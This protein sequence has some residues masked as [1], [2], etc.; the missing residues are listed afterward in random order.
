MGLKGS[1]GLADRKPCEVVDFVRGNC[2][3]SKGISRCPA[4]PTEVVFALDMSNDVSQSDFERMRDIL[5]S[6]LMK[7]EV[8]ESNCPTGARVA[9]VSY[10]MKTDYLVRLPDHRGQAGLLQAVRKIP[11]ERSSGSRNLGATMRFVA[12]HV[13]KRVRSGLLVR[14]V[15]VF[16]Q[17]GRNYDTTSVS[18]AMLELHAADI[19][20][21][22]VTFTEEH[23]LPEAQLVDGP[24]QFHLFTWETERQQDVERLASCTLCYDKCRPAPGC[25]LGAPR[26]QES[27]VDLVFLVD[28][29]QGVS[30]DIYLGALRLVD[31]V[32]QDL[33]V[34]AQPG[35]S[36]HG[37]RAA[38]LTHTAP[39]FGPGVAR[40]PVLQHFHL[41][42]HGHR[43]QMQR[44]LREAASGL[45]QGAPA[46][47]H[48]LEWT[49]ENVLL[50]A[51][52]PRRSRVLFAI[53]ASETSIWDR[54][55]LRALSQEAK[56]KGITLFVLALGPGVGA[57][58]LAELARVASAP[59]EQHL[60]R[61]EGVSEA[62][63]AYASRFTEAF[64][65]L[66]RS[67][68]NQYPPP[69]LM[70]EC[71]GPNRGDTLLHFY[72]SAKRF[73]RHQAGTS[74]ASAND[75]EAL[76]PPDIFLE[77]KRKSRMASV[78]LQEVLGSPGKDRVDTEETDQEMPAKGRRSG[79]G[80]GPCPTE[81][82]EGECRSHVLK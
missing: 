13:F 51:V 70:K 11:L 80:H 52:L 42:S 6:L 23:N 74:A 54:E 77:E 53:V 33:D 71:G 57:Q 75:S 9:I 49:L 37:A 36:W 64:L 21:A 60:L 48:A 19:V 61:L 68:I 55:K 32:L 78:A 1:K 12:R 16:F 35:T 59:S 4:F 34:A 44:Q 25:Q 26:P 56:C 66:L 69:E 27:D 50:A 43:T 20:T 39:G 65:N 7:L 40:A 14:K 15:A 3:C 73:S 28:S 63:V 81:P 10:N 2:L 5:L 58:E 79:A 47:G 46:L 31:S 24:N 29:S 45:L 22:V 30:R 18:T 72:S 67:G 38:L 62:E 76:E 82:E 41:T 8:S 17:V